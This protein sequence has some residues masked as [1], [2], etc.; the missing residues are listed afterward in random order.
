MLECFCEIGR[1][2]FLPAGT[3]TG[4]PLFYDGNFPAAGAHRT[5]PI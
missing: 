5:I 3:E 2:F 4:V 1:N